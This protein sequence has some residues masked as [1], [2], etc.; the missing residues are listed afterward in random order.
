MTVEELLM[1][2]RKYR[3]ERD[4]ADARF[5]LRVVEVERDHADLILSAGYAS[6]D[7]WLKTEGI[8][9]SARFQSFKRGLALVGIDWAREFG[10]PAVIQ[11]ARLP[12]AA[13]T[14]EP[15]EDVP[16]YK[17]AI[18]SWTADTGGTLAS[19]ETAE[20]LRRQVAPQ[21]ET[22]QAVRRQ[23]ELAKLRA[24]NV[25]LRAE[26]AKLRAELKSLKKTKSQPAAASG[27]PKVL[28]AQLQTQGWAGTKTDSPP[29]PGG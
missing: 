14:A 22:P 27:P 9:D 16:L 20:R 1:D 12:S 29:T 5:L 8:C 13:S 25:E 19:S 18:E 7:A 6:F 21:S 3:L 17:H 4:R 2:L 11:A 23:D 24:E 28:P 10:A 15:G 26:N